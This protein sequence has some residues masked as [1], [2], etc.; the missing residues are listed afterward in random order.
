[1]LWILIFLSLHL[2]SC[3]LSD[4]LNL[5]WY[6][7]R[8]IGGRIGHVNRGLFF[9]RVIWLCWVLPHIWSHWE[10]RDF[11]WLLCS[12]LGDAR[13]CYW[14]QVD[15]YQR[16]VDPMALIALGCHLSLITR[17][18]AFGFLIKR[19]IAHLLNPPFFGFWMG[20]IGIEQFLHWIL[21]FF[22]DRGRGVGG[23][24]VGNE[25]LVMDTMPVNQG[26]VDCIISFRLHPS[27]CGD[28]LMT[29]IWYDTLLVPLI[30]GSSSHITP[31]QFLF[32]AI[33]LFWIGTIFWTHPSV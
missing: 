4:H 17:E 7:V 28:C 27:S 1:M 12:E 11:G 24:E 21:P 25:Q 14:G 8:L 2:S 18:S 31:E 16:Q 29:W 19:R 10:G 26:T 23:L 5:I 20:G 13:N 15:C 32:G 6:P 9:F 30:W 33:R 3:A 22:L